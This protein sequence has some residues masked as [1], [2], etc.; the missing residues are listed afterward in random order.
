M[1]IVAFTSLQLIFPLLVLLSAPLPARGRLNGFEVKEHSIPLKE[2]RNGGPGKDG[3][4]AIYNPKFIPADQAEFLEPDDP[5]ISVT[6]AGKTRAYPI[7]ILNWHEVVNDA[8]GDLV[9]VVTYCPLCGTGMV[10]DRTIGE[11]PVEFGVSGLLYQS[12]VLLYDDRTESLWSQL[13]REAVAGRMTG[14]KLEWIPSQQT[15]WELW[16]ERHPDGKVLSTDTGHRRNY[17]RSPYL[18]YERSERLMFPVPSHNRAFPNKTWIWGIEIEGEAKAYPEKTLPLN[19]PVADTVGGTELT[20][21]RDKGGVQA[22]D[23][24]GNDVPIVR[25]FWFAWQA[26]HPETSIWNAEASE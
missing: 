20:L 6:H 8:I 3:I 11:K 26:F 7:R 15:T 14:T 21:T 5:V 16:R 19:Q 12:D 9:F 24:E 4:P 22:K 1:R 10:F 17:N 23:A 25:A 18:G 13:E 2:I